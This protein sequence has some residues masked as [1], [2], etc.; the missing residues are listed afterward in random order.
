LPL[1]KQNPT[2]EK[3]RDSRIIRLYFKTQA[4]AWSQN[5][6]RWFETFNKK[7]CDQ[8]GNALCRIRSGTKCCTCNLQPIGSSSKLPQPHLLLPIQSAWK[9]NLLYWYFLPALQI[10][11][12]PAFVERRWMWSKL[13]NSLYHWGDEIINWWWIWNFGKN[14]KILV[15]QCHPVGYD[16]HLFLV[17][18]QVKLHS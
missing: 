10:Q 8:S 7:I 1:S 5:Q 16:Q 11:S 3:Q 17:I 14:V 13:R 2:Y 6:N 12:P 18:Q 9:S 15:K 4:L